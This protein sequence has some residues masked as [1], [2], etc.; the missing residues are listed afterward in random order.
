VVRVVA[1]VV[2]IAHATHFTPAQ[3][4]GILRQRVGLPFAE[5]FAWGGIALL[6]VGGTLLA[7]GLLSR[8]VAVPLT[9]HMGLAIALI[10]IHEGLA[11][12]SGG[13]MQIALLLIAALLVV[14]V[15]GPGPV[16]LDR[17]IGWDNGWTRA[18]SGDATRN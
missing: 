4:G 18:P 17:L 5:V 13:G 8:L 12:R 11:P 16:S 2:L 6:Y 15:T 7:V 1:G 10:D 14:F 3:F 9:A